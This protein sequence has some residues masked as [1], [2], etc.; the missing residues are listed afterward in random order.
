MLICKLAHQDEVVL[1]FMRIIRC[2]MSFLVRLGMHVFQISEMALI[3]D[4]CR[5]CI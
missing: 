5:V 1:L 4:F 2:E 3:R